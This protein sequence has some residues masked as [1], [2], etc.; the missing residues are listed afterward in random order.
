[1][2]AIKFFPKCNG[3]YL[4]GE[5][6]SSR[7]FRELN[8]SDLKTYLIFRAKCRYVG[9]SEARKTGAKI[10]TI[11]NNGM[12][13]FSYAEAE[14]YG[15]PQ[16]TFSRS[17]TKLIDLGIIDVKIPGGINRTTKYEISDRWRKYGTDDFKK[18]RRQKRTGNKF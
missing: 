6:L 15:I 5:F 18:K 10:G 4:E 11:K 12:I 17:I 13:E 1:M 14:N 9:K 3:V 7:A 16:T 8:L 2:S